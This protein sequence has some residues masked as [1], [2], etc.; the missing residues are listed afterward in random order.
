[1]TPRLTVEQI[2]REVGLMWKCSGGHPMMMMEWSFT[3]GHGFR[4]TLVFLK[5]LV[6]AWEMAGELR[7]GWPSWQPCG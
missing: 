4:F 7:E 1:M 3:D 6:H 5:L 2:R